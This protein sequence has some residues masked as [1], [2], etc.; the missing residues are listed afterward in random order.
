MKEKMRANQAIY[1]CGECKKIVHSLKD[2]FFVEEI[3]GR[4]FCSEVCIQH[5]YSKVVNYFDDIEKELRKNKKLEKEDALK[6]IAD[7]KKLEVVMG[8]PDEIWSLSNEIGEKF[9]SYI[10]CIEEDDRKQYIIVICFVYDFAPSFVIS[11]TATEDQE[12]LN[13]YRIGEKVTDI[14]AFLKGRVVRQDINSGLDHETVL[15]LEN[16]KSQM[17]ARILDKRVENDI[18]FE[19]HQKYF[20]CKDDTLRLPDEV[21]QSQDD[22]GDT[23]NTYIKSYEINDEIFYYFVMCINYHGASEEEFAL[24]FLFFPSKSVDIYNMIKSGSCLEGTLKN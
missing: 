17:L 20:D 16:K 15:Y 23:V 12:L 13:E 1:I 9:Y 14:G 3:P 18:P 7:R 24:P 11:V 2:L 10:S 22:D 8:K 6:H 21:Y 4:G 19:H 5:F